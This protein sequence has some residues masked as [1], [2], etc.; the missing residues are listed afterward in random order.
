MLHQQYSRLRQRAEGEATPL[1]L[2]HIGEEKTLVLSGSGEQPGPTQWL[3]IGSHKTSRDW[4]R[5]QPPTADE[6]EVAIMV[7][8]DE[9]I[10]IE[11]MIASASGL[12]SDD[13]DLRQLALI[14]GVSE[15]PEPLM[16]LDTVE[17]TF[18]RL[19]AVMGGRPAHWEGI[20]PEREFAARLLILREFMHHLRFADIGIL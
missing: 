7:V 13:S 14:A 16:T 1:T 17:R 4:F 3:S 20:P 2:L 18:D 6:M 9:V 11:P 5:H 10:R 12:F 19:A 8:E 15:Q